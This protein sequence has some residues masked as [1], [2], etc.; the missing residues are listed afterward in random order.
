ML[1]PSKRDFL[2]INESHGHSGIV[3]GAER[4]RSGFRDRTRTERK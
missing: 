3:T 2:S 4:I 1:T